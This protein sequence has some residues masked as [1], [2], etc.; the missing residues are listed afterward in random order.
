MLV[1]SATTRAA[2]SLS[3]AAGS[4]RSGPASSDPEI[5]GRLL[6]PALSAE[7]ASVNQAYAPVSRAQ[8]RHSTRNRAA[9]EDRGA[10]SVPAPLE[11]PPE[12]KRL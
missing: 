9:F 3:G 11:F 5:G 8:S 6:P 4:D 2:E 10:V 12:G 1:S 7:R